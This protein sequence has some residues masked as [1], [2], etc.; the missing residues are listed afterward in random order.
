[1]EK[2]VELAS[3]N[4]VWRGMDYY[5]KNKVVDWTRTGEQT[6]SGT[7]QG[8]NLYHVSIDK[9]HPRRST[10]DCPFAAGRRVVCKH[11]IALLFTAEPDV[12]KNL[13]REVEEWERDE[14]LR[15]EGER[16][17]RRKELEDYVRGLSKK[18]LQER[19][20]QALIDIDY[21]QDEERYW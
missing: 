13:Y 11:M 10:C 21:L 16:R 6:Y 20:V 5:E 3:S 8:E 14:E 12:P 7:V 1:M 2:M 15:I 4:S 18:E 19:L 9:E 17:Q